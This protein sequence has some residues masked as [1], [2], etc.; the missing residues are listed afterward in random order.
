[1]KCPNCNTGELRPLSDSVSMCGSCGYLIEPQAWGMYESTDIAPPRTEPDLLD[2]F[3]YAVA[4]L[5][6]GFGL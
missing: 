3:A 2:R 4:K 6:A 5:L 1:M